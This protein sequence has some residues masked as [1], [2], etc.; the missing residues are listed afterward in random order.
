[1]RDIVSLEFG[2]STRPQLEFELKP[3][4]RGPGA[5]I[6]LSLSPTIT[7]FVPELTR[8]P[9][10]RTPED[11]DAL[12]L[13]AGRAVRAIRLG[14]GLQRY[15]IDERTT[16]VPFR[17]RSDLF[18]CNFVFY[19]DKLRH[20]VT[21]APPYVYRPERSARGDTVYELVSTDPGRS[22]GDSLEEKRMEDIQ[23]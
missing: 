21:W 8:K 14:V 15:G 22:V 9:D 11:P 1:M 19:F 17:D 10:G 16:C 5:S 23:A 12:E 3:I 2:L 4:R 13:A 18:H 7:V 6:R 20:K